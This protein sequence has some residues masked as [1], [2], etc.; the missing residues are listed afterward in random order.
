MIRG[1]YDTSFTNCELIFL[2]SK[3]YDHQLYYI[4]YVHVD[5][6]VTHSTW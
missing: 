1:Y 2:G 3:E 6:I 4:L 5:T